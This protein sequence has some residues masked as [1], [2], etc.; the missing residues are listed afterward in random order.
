MQ[1]RPAEPTDAIAWEGMRQALWPSDPGEHAGEIA[2]FFAGDR[3]NPAEVLLAFDDH[4][5]AIGF[6]EISIRPY[7]EECYSGHV[8]FLEGWFVEEDHRR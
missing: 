8:A 2:A 3:R 1:I 6:A 5:K 4:G 7:A